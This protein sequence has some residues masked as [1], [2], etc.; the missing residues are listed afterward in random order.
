MIAPS[1]IIRTDSSQQIGSGHLMRCLTLADELRIRGAAV[2]FVCRELPGHQIDF[3]EVK[4]YAV[5]RLKQSDDEF[6]SSSDDLA[7]ATWLGVPWEQDAAET[8][9]V[10]GDV[11]P[12][13]LIID[14]YAIDSRWEETLRPHVGRIMVI[15]DIADRIHDSE[16]LLDQNLYEDMDTRYNGLISGACTNLLGPGYALLRPEFNLERS[17]LRKRDGVVRRI[18][19]FFGGIDST[20]ETTKALEVL[21]MLDRPDI[22]IDVVVGGANP[23]KESI[24][25]ICQG[26]PTAS[27]Y[28]QVNN[29]AKLMAAADL[30]IGAGGATTWERCALGLPALVI[31]VA[32]NQINIARSADKAGVLTYL[33]ESSNV[34]VF[35]LFK[36]LSEMCSN[37]GFVNDQSEKAFQLI[38]GIG[39][40]RVAD[41]MELQ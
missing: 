29:M 33:G 41:K 32:E 22:A 27:Y 16:L 36:K 2:T 40:R 3:A 10:L 6:S 5:L 11:H 8:L 7:H 31:S 26:F 15:D 1:I 14:H 9:A 37:V 20:N 35:D 21:R 23:H 39:V 24:E 4:G 30:S 17:T 19:V 13:W 38:D 28:C 18:L 34:N 25:V 12:D